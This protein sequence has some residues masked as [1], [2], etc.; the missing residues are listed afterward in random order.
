VRKAAHILLEAWSRAKIPGDLILVGAVE[1]EIRGLCADHLDR[2]DVHT[3]GFVADPRTVY[4][5]A[6]I[7]VMPSLEEGSP[8]VTYEAAAHGLPMIVSP[9]GAGRI[10]AEEGC[11]VAFDPAEPD[12]LVAALRRLAA[13]PEER[14]HFGARARAVAQN[15]DW[16][17]V[18]A[19]RLAQLRDL[20]EG[21]AGSPPSGG[22]QPSL[23]G[24]AEGAGSA[25]SG[26]GAASSAA[27]RAEMSISGGKGLPAAAASAARA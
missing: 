25:P 3:P 20:L 11:A 5:A 24:A 6:D 7:F 9:M 1:P 4:G 2:P 21:R 26:G 27:R 23:S 19:R 16:R 22:T 13:S 15:Y 12:T 8:L 17:D 14:R 18:S 10:G